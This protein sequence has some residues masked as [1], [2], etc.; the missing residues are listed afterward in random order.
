MWRE[1]RQISSG[2]PSFEKNSVFPADSRIGQWDISFR[3][4]PP[5]P[6]FGKTGCAWIRYIYCRI[7]PIRQVISKWIAVIAIGCMARASLAGG[8]IHGALAPRFEENAGQAPG[9]V[10]FV[11]RAPGYAAAFD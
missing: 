11:L 10:R 3:F 5:P 9:N 6:G 2:R 7:G 1:F 8:P 4:A